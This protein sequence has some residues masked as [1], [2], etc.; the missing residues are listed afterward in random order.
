MGL[1]IDQVER[2]AT[3]LPIFIDEL[4]Y[5]TVPETDFLDLEF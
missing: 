5:E 2:L 1:A 4:C 3:E